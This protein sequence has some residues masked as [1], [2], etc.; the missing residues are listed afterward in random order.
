MRSQKFKF[1]TDGNP[2]TMTKFLEEFPFI[3][4]K[5]GK[6]PTVAK[7]RFKRF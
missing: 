6:L 7:E 4:N 1:I 2:V 3:F 5:A